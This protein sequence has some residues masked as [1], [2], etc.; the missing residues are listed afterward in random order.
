VRFVL[1]VLSLSLSLSLPDA[2]SGGASASAAV[3]GRSTAGNSQR[4]EMHLVTYTNETVCSDALP[5]VGYQ[6]YTAA[7]YQLVYNP[8]DEGLAQTSVV[9]MSGS[10]GVPTTN[11]PGWPGSTDVQPAQ[12]AANDIMVASVASSLEYLFYIISPRDIVVARPRDY[13][14]HMSFLLA[15]PA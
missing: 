3:A 13:D 5:I 2:V 14:D 15:E 6:H 7:D 8:N 4:P 10:V 1:L 12:S 9:G 11:S